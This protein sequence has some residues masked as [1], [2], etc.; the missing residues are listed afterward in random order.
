MNAFWASENF[1]AFI[2]LR[3]SHPGICVEDSNQNDQFCGLR[4]EAQICAGMRRLKELEDENGK[5]KK[6]VAESVARPREL[7]DVIRRKL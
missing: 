4:A 3:S 6:L 5:L 7:Q 2:V 1:K